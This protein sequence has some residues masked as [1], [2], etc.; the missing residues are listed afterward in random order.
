MITDRNS[1][2]QNIIENIRKGLEKY[3]DYF[4]FLIFNICMLKRNPNIVYM[5]FTVQRCNG[6]HSYN[7]EDRDRHKWTY[8]VKIVCILCRVIQYYL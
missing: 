5:V 1:D 8:M 7:M 2:V 3:K 4:L 6:Y